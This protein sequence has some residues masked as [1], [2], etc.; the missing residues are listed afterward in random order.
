MLIQREDLRNRFIRLL[1]NGSLTSLTKAVDE[2]VRRIS[3][4]LLMQVILNSVFGVAVAA[5]LWLIGVPYA[6][7]WG[8]LGAMFRYVPYVGTPIACA[9]P[10]LLSLAMLPGWTRPLMVVGVFL[11]CDLIAYYVA[12]P[13]L[14]GKSIGVSAVAL[15]ISAAF[16]GWLWGPIGLVL[17]TPLTACLAVLGKFV[18][19]FEFLNVLLGDEPVLE[20][21]VSL[22]QRLLARDSDEAVDLVEEFARDHTPAE[23]YDQV[24]IP[25]LV[26]AKKNRDRG[27]YTEEDERYILEAYADMLDE[28][29]TPRDHTK[30][31]TAHDP[32][33]PRVLVLA[34][35][36]HDE[37]DR[38]ALLLFQHLLGGSRCHFEVL[39]VQKL[40]AE[41]IDQIDHDE[42]AA[43]FVANLPPGGLSHTRYLCKRVRTRFPDLKVLV[44]FWGLEGDSDVLRRRLVESGAD[45]VGTTLLE[46]RSQLL[47]HVQLHPHLE[48]AAV[49]K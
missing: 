16:W 28:L 15:L 40:T 9:L 49:S 38:V 24:L 43:L 22:Y 19:Q 30:A 12:E 11:G 3:R 33:A 26:L 20:P 48:E 41:V 10:A 6:A 1:G 14:Y 32:A 17:S 27:D 37:I 46:S 29:P 18:P 5:G 8:F 21:H 44:G 34:C 45:H 4:F 25:A 13:W 47:P 39:S 36:A 31:E 7:L 2:G 23:L 42:P 35:P